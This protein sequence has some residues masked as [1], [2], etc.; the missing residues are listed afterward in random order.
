MRIANRL[1]CCW[2]V[3]IMAVMTCCFL[4][5]RA[6]SPEI[7]NKVRPGDNEIHRLRVADQ[8]ERRGIMKKSKSEWDQ[9]AQ[10]D[11]A[12]RKRA[13][14][15]YRSGSLKTGGDFF[16]AALI[17]QH[18]DKPDDYLLAHVLC[19]IAIA[20]G[21]NADARWLSAATLDRYLQA[22]QQKQI[23]GTQYE[24]DEKK[25]YSNGPYNSGLLTD[26]VRR[27]LEVPTLEQQKRDVENLNKSVTANK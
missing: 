9:M 17:L 19:T 4:L 7:E 12:R 25:G 16:D 6:Q 8:D 22:I 5:V 14:E 26:S 21:N 13:L 20:K 27:A 1:R 18:G 11:V 10:H 23:F 24:G 2:T 3:A 15:I